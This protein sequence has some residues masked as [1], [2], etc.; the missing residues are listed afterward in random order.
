MPLVEVLRPRL[1]PMVPDERVA[2]RLRSPRRLERPVVPTRPYLLS[3]MEI[4]LFFK[5]RRHSNFLPRGADRRGPSS[6]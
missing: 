5:R 1:Q 6:R 4:A 3:G 2:R